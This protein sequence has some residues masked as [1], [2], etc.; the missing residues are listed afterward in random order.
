[1]ISGLALEGTKITCQ[2]ALQIDV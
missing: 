1:V 2:S